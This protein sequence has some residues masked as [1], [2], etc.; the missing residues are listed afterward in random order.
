MET[1]P[2]D[3]SCAVCGRRLMGCREIN[4]AATCARAACLVAAHRRDPAWTLRYGL[5][6]G[7]LAAA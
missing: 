4:G 3:R 5:G 7:R 1:F 6:G 2:T